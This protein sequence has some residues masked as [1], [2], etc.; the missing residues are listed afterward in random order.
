MTAH[1][2][3]ALDR[4]V[5]L[6][7][8]AEAPPATLIYLEDATEPGLW[9]RLTAHLHHRFDGQFSQIIYRH[10]H[11]TREAGAR[12]ECFGPE[13]D[14][15][16][17]TA[18]GARVLIAHSRTASAALAWTGNS[19]RRTR[20]LTALVL[21]APVAEEVWICGD[22]ELHRLRM[23]PTWVV[24]DRTT[25]I[26]NQALTAQWIQ[27]LWADHLAMS[28]GGHRFPSIDP[29]RA[30]EPTLAALRVAYDTQLREGA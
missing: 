11:S 30:A 1:T 13:L 5:I 22:D 8:G 19:Q 6:R 15:V 28:S 7:T 18:A 21:F 4:P 9:A 24:T 25:G 27:M 10:H 26:D 17:D 23:V 2:P 29:V 16:L 20:M 14:V 12:H 3:P